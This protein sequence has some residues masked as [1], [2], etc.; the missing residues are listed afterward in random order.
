MSWQAGMNDVGVPVEPALTGSQPRP[1][2]WNW[3]RD[4]AVPEPTE[5]TP[6]L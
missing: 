2:L 3:G 6:L 1:G 4:G 5:T